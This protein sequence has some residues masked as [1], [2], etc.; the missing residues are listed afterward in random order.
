MCL[1]YNIKTN[2]FAKYYNIKSI[3]YFLKKD[4]SRISVPLKLWNYISKQYE[5]QHFGILLF[6]FHLFVCFGKVAITDVFLTLNQN[7]NDIC[8]VIKR[9]KEF[10]NLCYVTDLGLFCLQKYNYYI[11]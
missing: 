7:S 10:P 2:I 1:I 3:I 9:D 5:M 11:R 8:R 6:L 4:Y